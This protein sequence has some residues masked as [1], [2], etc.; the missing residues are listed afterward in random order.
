MAGGARASA[1]VLSLHGA[2]RAL[3]LQGV[4]LAANGVTFL[5]RFLI[6]HFVLF[7]NR[8]GEAPE[9]AG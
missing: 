8:G 4:Y 5:A 9:L 7:A 1:A 3:F 6:F 2:E